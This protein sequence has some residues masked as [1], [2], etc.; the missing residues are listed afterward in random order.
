MYTLCIDHYQLKF[1]EA[2]GVANLA[3]SNVKRLKLPCSEY[4][5]IS[6]KKSS[7]FVLKKKKRIHHS[8]EGPGN[9]N[10]SFS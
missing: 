4:S 3:G 9:T 8:I 7:Q 1:V 5:Y 2:A 6:A 10:F